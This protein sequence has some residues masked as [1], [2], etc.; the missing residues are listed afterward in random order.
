M[1]FVLDASITASWAFE[2]E[3]TPYADRVLDTLAGE[4]A[5]TPAIWLLEVTNVLVAGE[6]R[7][8]IQPSAT[9]AFLTLLEALPIVVLVDTSWR[10]MYRLADLARTYNLSAYDA[11]YLDLAMSQAAPLA[12]LDHAL[13]VAA[14]RAGVPLLD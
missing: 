12:T 5:V 14:E 3:I 10:I 11:A 2:D 9:A 13:R 8:R 7:G 4:S 1:P 6:R